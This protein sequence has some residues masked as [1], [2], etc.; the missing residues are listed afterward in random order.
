MLCVK[1][2]GCLY[3]TSKLPRYLQS[4][5]VC[6]CCWLLSCS[7]W[8]GKDLE[9]Q[10]SPQNVCQVGGIKE[11]HLVLLTTSSYPKLVTLLTTS[12]KVNIPWGEVKR[13]L[14]PN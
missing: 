2:R 5:L 1:E 14:A 7:W 8:L 10:V 9:Q 4:S 13:G 12:L 6:Q 11:Q 3:L